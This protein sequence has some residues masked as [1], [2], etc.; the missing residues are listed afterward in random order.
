VG[1]LSAGWKSS[2]SLGRREH[3]AGERPAANL[4]RWENRFGA[5]RGRDL[6]ISYERNVAREVQA[7]ISFYW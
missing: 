2:F 1:A 7:A 5:A 4:L 3:L 6:R